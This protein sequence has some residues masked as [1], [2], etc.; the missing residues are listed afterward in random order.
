MIISANK[1]RYIKLGRK[2]SWEQALDEG[3]VPFGYD[4][5]SHE[6]AQQGKFEEIRTKLMDRGRPQQAAARD[7]QEITD[8]YQLGEDCLWITFARDRLWWAFAE[9]TVLTTGKFGPHPFRIR[10]TIGGWSDKDVRGATLKTS[11]LSTKLTKVSNYKRTICEVGAKDYLLRRI[12]GI[13]EP[14]VIKARDA[15]TTDFSLILAA[16]LTW[17]S[18]A[19]PPQSQRSRATA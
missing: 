1:V 7:V 11:Y 5:A 14:I 4:S 18:R 15:Q 9:P 3:V 19:P 2:G 8:F 6:L 12:N 17:L 16:P 10:K 13:E